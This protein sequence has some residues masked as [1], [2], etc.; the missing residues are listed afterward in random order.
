VDGS[1]TP[2]MTPASTAHGT[3]A[4]HRGVDGRTPDWLAAEHAAIDA[5]PGAT[6]AGLALS[7][8][9]IRSAAVCLGVLQAMEAA[10]LATRF[11]WLSTVSGGGYTGL[12]WL[13]RAAGD[14]ERS[15]RFP[16]TRPETPPHR[17]AATRTW[18]PAAPLYH[19]RNRASYLL[20]PGLSPVLGV[21]AMVGRK[22]LVN[23]LVLLP[24]VLGLAALIAALG[25]I[26]LMLTAFGPWLGRGAVVL[27]GL[28]AGAALLAL[29][30]EARDGGPGKDDPP[31]VRAGLDRAA[32]GVLVGLIIA[33][34]AILL[35]SLPQVSG[36]LPSW[37]WLGRIM[38]MASNIS[39][40]G[41]IA[42][43]GVLFGGG[44]I[45]SA[46]RG[47]RMNIVLAA[48]VALTML[49]LLA[50]TLRIATDTAAQF[51][52]PGTGEAAIAAAVVLLFL[53]GLAY[54]V[55]DVF[56]DA[57]ALSLHGFYRDRLA[58]AFFGDAGPSPRLSELLP[59]QTGGPLPIVNATVAGAAG[60]DLARR[61]RPAGPFT[62][63]PLTA[64]N[65][66]AGRCP[67][68]QLEARER[69]F[70]AAAA[71]ALSA[72]AISPQAGRATGSAAAVILKA[73]LNLRTGRWLPNPDAVAKD[74]PV[75]RA[76][77]ME[78]WR[79]ILPFASRSA[80]DGRLLVSDG[81]HWE[82]LGVLSLVHRA[83]P[84]IVAIDAEADPDL[85][86]NGLAVATMLSRLD[87][88][89]E[90]RLDTHPLARGPEGLSTRHCVTG[91]IVAGSSGARIGRILYVKATLTGDEPV[92]VQHYAARHPAFP[93]EA[94][95]DQ[96][97]DEAQFEAYRALGEHIGAEVVP[98]LRRLMEKLDAW[99]AAQLSRSAPPRP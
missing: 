30:R 96:F 37:D 34:G 20:E 29:R 39:L 16:Y 87:A 18:K 74:T 73:L 77:L 36:W 7:G 33:L 61:G 27:A 95:A 31:R 45:A 55:L 15:G 80:A 67:T 47:R 59:E 9:G 57:N 24:L 23:L 97:F 71:M 69:G 52:R 89:A 50:I 78:L 10:G 72:A 26:G 82:N 79:D 75:A 40:P 32:A 4:A 88:D 90:I 56:V 3:I 19:L 65:G 1:A 35:A 99:D 76:G 53:A 43:L 41:L 17:D 44:A 38:Q 62:F 58:D 60:R 98:E 13:A 2:G 83:C 11:G 85:A 91:E 14:P 93:H 22:L 42:V 6:R 81:G 54:V 21:L 64:G 84:L 48:I 25:V 94:T 92:D 12:G 5:R 68:R 86:F 49:V 66:S 51:A 28:G 46:L 8:G 70:D 63:T